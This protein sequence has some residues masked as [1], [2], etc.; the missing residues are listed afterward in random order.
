MGMVATSDRREAVRNW[1]RRTASNQDGEEGEKGRRLTRKLMN[2][3]DGAD[4][5]GGGRKQ[6]FLRRG[7]RGND[8]A[9]DDMEHPGSI[10]WLE[11]D[12]GIKAQL[13]VVSDHR[14]MAGAGGSTARGWRWFSVS[15][16]GLADGGL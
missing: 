9:G 5:V 13:L 4:E 3:S 10:S 16:T 11:E 6:G 8:E 2:T 15:E 14:G 7:R 12:R 1:R